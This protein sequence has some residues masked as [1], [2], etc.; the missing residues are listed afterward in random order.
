MRLSC[1]REKG[2]YGS[3]QTGKYRYEEYHTGRT[4]P[5]LL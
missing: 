4:D 1:R 5:I 2:D 3:Y